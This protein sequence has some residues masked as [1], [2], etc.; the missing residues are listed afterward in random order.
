[1]AAGCAH[2]TIRT[3][4]VDRSVYCIGGATD[5]NAP[6]PSGSCGSQLDQHEPAPFDAALT[7]TVAAA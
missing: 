1:M 2:V 4:R 3:L 6:A 7:G 5:S